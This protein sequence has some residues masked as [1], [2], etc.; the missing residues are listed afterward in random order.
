MA[1]AI[2]I[3]AVKRHDIDGKELYLGRRQS[4]LRMWWYGIESLDCRL[5]FEL[6]S[7]QYFIRSLIT[8]ILR[9]AI[10]LNIERTTVQSE[11]HFMDMHIIDH[12]FV[13]F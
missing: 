3:G 12:H 5:T 6:W 4:T 10:G 13:R 1:A 9:S 11:N 7:F 2:D 8:K